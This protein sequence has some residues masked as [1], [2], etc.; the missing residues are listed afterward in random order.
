MS[1]RPSNSLVIRPRG[2]ASEQLTASRRWLTTVGMPGWVVA[3]R[4]SLNRFARTASSPV[5]RRSF[6]RIFRKI[7]L[8][9][10]KVLQQSKRRR[11]LELFN[12]FIGIDGNIS[13]VLRVVSLFPIYFLVKLVEVELPALATFMQRSYQVTFNYIG[14]DQFKPIA[15]FCKRGIFPKNTLNWIFH[16]PILSTETIVRPDF[17]RYWRLMLTGQGYSGDHRA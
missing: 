5:P 3:R 15:F 16:M 2:E 6:A 10:R 4:I 14:I 7:A 12:L 1:T 9:T 8:K 13:V 17:G 11:I